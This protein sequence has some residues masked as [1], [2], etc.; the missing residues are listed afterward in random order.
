MSSG[1][2]KE[3]CENFLEVRN[4]ECGKIIFF[5]I[6][7]L[8]ISSHLVMG[9]LVFIPRFSPKF[10]QGQ[11]TRGKHLILLR[12]FHIMT[13]KFPSIIYYGDLTRRFDYCSHV[14][15]DTYLCFCKE[16]VGILRVGSRLRLALEWS[17]VSLSLDASEKCY[18]DS[19]GHLARHR[20]REAPGFGWTSIQKT[21]S[22][23]ISQVI[24]R[25]NK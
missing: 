18:L 8:L 2:I 11:P 1:K 12:P 25:I 24:F 15:V 6:L 22:T 7:F 14:E 16:Q 9:N 13:S 21:R 3:F 19:D 23:M 4:S 5:M 17:R 20:T 10:L